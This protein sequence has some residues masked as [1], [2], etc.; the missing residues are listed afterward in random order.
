MKSLTLHPYGCPR[1]AK[2]YYFSSTSS[3]EGKE[4]RE[5]AE[6]VGLYWCGERDTWISG[7]SQADTHRTM[8]ESQ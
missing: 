3:L 6:E 4:P 8:S 7:Q 1:A 2:G 5:G